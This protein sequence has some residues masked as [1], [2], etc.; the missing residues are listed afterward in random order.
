MAVLRALGVDAVTL[1]RECMPGVVMSSFAPE[2]TKLRRF[3]SKAGGFG[4]P[5]TIVRIAEAARG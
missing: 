5:E 3:V 1:E 4:G 2:G